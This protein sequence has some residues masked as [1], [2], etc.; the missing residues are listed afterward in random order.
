MFSTGIE[1]RDGQFR[2]TDLS[3]TPWYKRRFIRYDGEKPTQ[4]VDPDRVT[5]RGI[6]LLAGFFGLVI[7]MVL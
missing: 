2:T 4:L 6:L 5:V 3:G 7:Y 1:V